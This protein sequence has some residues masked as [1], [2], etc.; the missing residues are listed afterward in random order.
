MAGTSPAMTLDWLRR[1]LRARCV[2][3]KLPARR[4]A[5]GYEKIVPLTQPGI[6][7]HRTVGRAQNIE[8]GNGALER[9]KCR[10]FTGAPA[11]DKDTQI[12]HAI[13]DLIDGIAEGRDELWVKRQDE[14]I[15]NLRKKTSKKRR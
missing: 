11:A 5:R 4:A 7:A 3:L 15:A 14:H 10:F 8:T 9:G 13:V 6:G 2:F 1:A 12:A